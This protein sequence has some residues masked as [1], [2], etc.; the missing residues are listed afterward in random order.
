MKRRILEWW[1][2]IVKIEKDLA[3][4]KPTV[5]PDPSGLNLL[6]PPPSNS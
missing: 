6:R 4:R 5:P 2:A 1:A 3:R